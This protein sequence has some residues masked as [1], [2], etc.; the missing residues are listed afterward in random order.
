MKTES[1]NTYISYMYIAGYGLSKE[2]ILVK[3]NAEYIKF[4]GDIFWKSVL[5]YVYHYFYVQFSI[6][7]SIFNPLEGR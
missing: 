1:I 4:K 3:S 5:C 6:L 7:L 2:Y